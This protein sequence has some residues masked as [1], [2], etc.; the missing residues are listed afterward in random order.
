MVYIHATP[1]HSTFPFEVQRKTLL[2][3]PSSTATA[4]V[5]TA[6]TSPGRVKSGETPSLALQA[7]AQVIHG[8]MIRVDRVSWMATATCLKTQQKIDL[9]M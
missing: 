7:F 1:T 4:T 8:T 9:L 6:A 5:A 3:F 2:A